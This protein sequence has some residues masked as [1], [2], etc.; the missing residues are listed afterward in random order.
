MEQSDYRQ[1]REGTL[2]IDIAKRERDLLKEIHYEGGYSLYIGIPFCPT[3]CLYCSLTSYPIVAFRRQVD[4]YVD[5][6]IKEMGYVAENFKDKVLDTVYIG[7]GTPTTLE[8]EQLDRLITALKSKSDFSTMKE[9]TGKPVV[10]TASQR[11]AGGTASS[12][13]SRISVNPRL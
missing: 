7:G 13:V 11:E 6:V 12:Q 3:T 4:A 8:P 10:P 1:S 5:A 9:F 2:G